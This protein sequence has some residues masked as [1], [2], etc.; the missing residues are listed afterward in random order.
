MEQKV[1]VSGLVVLSFFILIVT[2]NISFDSD[3]SVIVDPYLDNLFSNN[4]ISGAA[5]GLSEDETVS[6]IITL[7]DDEETQSDDLEERKEAIKDLQEEVLDNLDVDLKEQVT[8][9]E[10]NP[11]EEIEI[12][13]VYSTI[14]ALSAEVTEEGLE[15][16]KDDPNVERVDFNYPLKLSLD[17]SVPLINAD[18]VWDISINGASLDGSGETVCVI[19]TGADYT[20]PALG[21][22]TTEEFL[23]GNCNKVIAGYDFGNDDDDPTPFR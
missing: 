5:V 2:S 8:I 3:S 4:L 10:D 6:V 12:D 7:K 9:N 13:H 17:G 15:K 20:H 21:G 23:A 22:C 19:D 1:W 16:L 14:N 11:P 18:D